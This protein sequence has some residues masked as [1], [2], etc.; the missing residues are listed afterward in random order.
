MRPVLNGNALFVWDVAT[1]PR[2]LCSEEARREGVVSM[3]FLPVRD[4]HGVRGIM[5]LYFSEKKT[6]D[7]ED[8]D[9]LET[10]AELSGFILEGATTREV[11]A[12][13]AESARRD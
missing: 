6:F 13:A 10:L 7:R 11:L 3:V 8:L 5:Q 2:I 9:F 1:D 4:P 12:K